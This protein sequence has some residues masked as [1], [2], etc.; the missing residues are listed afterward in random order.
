[1]RLIYTSPLLYLLIFLQVSFAVIYLY[2]GKA[3]AASDYFSLLQKDYFLWLI[4]IPILAIQHK[5]GVFSTFYGCISRVGGIRRMILADFLTLAAS[6]CL[7]VSA[8]LFTPLIFL[9]LKGSAPVSRELLTGMSFFLTRYVLVGLLIQYVLYAVRYAFPDF[10]KRGGSICAV[11]FLLFCVF[12]FPMEFL[13]IKGLYPQ[14][15]DFSA[16]GSVFF[17]ADGLWETVVLRNLHLVAYLALFA[18]ITVKYLSVKW[19][20]LENESE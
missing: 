20:F 6:T 12:T 17:T 16:G 1:M 11:P 8:V 10:Q 18:F 7:S 5:A 14:L 15:L 9:W 13:R 4:C 3:A 2:V 19:E